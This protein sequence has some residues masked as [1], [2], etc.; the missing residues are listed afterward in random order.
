MFERGCECSPEEMRALAVF[1]WQPCH[2]RETTPLSFV[3]DLLRLLTSAFGTKR[4]WQSRSVMSAFGG[5]ADVLRC[6][7]FP[8]KRTFTATGGV[9]DFRVFSGQSAQQTGV[10]AAAKLDAASIVAK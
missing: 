7:L 8:R 6:P 1:Y 9:T 2:K 4:T 5:K 10:S 3:I